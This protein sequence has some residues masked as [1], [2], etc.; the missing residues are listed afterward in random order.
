MYTNQAITSP[1]TEGELNHYMC[2]FITAQLH[3]SS[4]SSH[5]HAAS[6][7]V[8][9][10]PARETLQPRVELKKMK[11]NTKSHNKGHLK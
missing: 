9:T 1:L 3:R 11:K 5:L 10:T 6:T 4:E 2:F 7:G 8:G